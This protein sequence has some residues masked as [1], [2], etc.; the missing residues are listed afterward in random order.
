MK[1]S[2]C[3]YETGDSQTGQHCARGRPQQKSRRMRWGTAGFAAYCCIDMC[4][5]HDRDEARCAPRPWTKDF[6]PEVHLPVEQLP[7]GDPHTI[8]KHCISV[9]VT[10]IHHRQ[11]PPKC[12][13]LPGTSSTVDL[14]KAA[15]TPDCHWTR[16]LRRSCGGARTQSL[17]CHARRR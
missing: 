1:D 8:C 3:A 11:Q 9:F 6:S 17:R 7:L 5:N 4:V 16:C 2:T 10:A 15:Y 14:S 12:I 13:S